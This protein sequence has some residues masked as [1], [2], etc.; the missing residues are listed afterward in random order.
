MPGKCSCLDGNLKC[1]DAAPAMCAVGEEDNDIESFD[2]DSISYRGGESYD[3]TQC[4][5]YK[6]KL[7]KFSVSLYSWQA[8]TMA[9]AVF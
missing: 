8:T 2:E 5:I 4:L 3:E 7:T 6:E 1:A 9:I